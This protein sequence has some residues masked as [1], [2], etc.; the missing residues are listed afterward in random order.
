VT[1]RRSAD[2]GRST[3]AARVLLADDHVP[4]RAGVRMA[5]AGEEFEV[6]AEVATA[7]AAVEAAM[8]LTPDLCLLDLVMPGGGISATQRIH[9]QQPDVKIVVLTVSQNED[10]LFEALIAGASGYMLKDA[11]STRLPDALRGVLAGEAALP[12]HLEWRLIERFR[13][14]EL[15]ERRSRRLLPKRRGKE[16]DLTRREWEVLS[17]FSRDFPT[18]VVA[19]RLGISEVTVRRHMSSAMSKLDVP[20]RASAVE[21]VGREG[22]LE[23][24]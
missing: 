10:D 1:H 7:D 9:A 20:D 4:T 6:V 3:R 8:R 22:W 14:R 5:L 2:A 23:D 12:R 13:K 18:T 24:S 21:L 11:S 19:R 15:R 16:P 17:L